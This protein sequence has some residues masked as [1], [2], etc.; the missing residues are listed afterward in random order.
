MADP[1]PLQWLIDQAIG[2]RSAPLLLA[3]AAG[4]F[5]A[6]APRQGLNAVSTLSNFRAANGFSLRLRRDAIRHAGRQGAG[7]HSRVSPGHNQFP[8][9]RD[10][11]LLTDSLHRGM[12]QAIALFT[13]VA[14]AALAVYH[15]ESRLLLAA[16]PLNLSP[17]A[18][19]RRFGP[20]LNDAA[21][22][23]Q[24]AAAAASATL[25][26]HLNAITQ[27]QLPPGL[28]WRERFVFSGS[29]AYIRA[30]AHKQKTEL[31]FGAGAGLVTAGGLSSPILIAGPRLVP[32]DMTA[33]AFLG[34]YLC[35]GQLCTPA[36]RWSDPVN[37]LTQTR[38][39]LARV[40]AFLTEPVNPSEC[41]HPQGSTAPA[42]VDLTNVAFAFPGAFPGGAAILEI[43]R[44]TVNP[45]EIL[46][47]IG[48][49]GSGKTILA[50]LPLR[51]FDPQ[52]GAIRYNGVRLAEMELRVLRGVIAF[53]P[54]SPLFF[55]GTIRD[56]LRA[57]W[58]QFQR[59]LGSAA[60]GR[61]RSWGC[62]DGI[63]SGRAHG[64]GRRAAF[65]RGT[66]AS[67]ACPRL[68]AERRHSDSG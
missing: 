32:G 21:A 54:Q 26:D 29:V 35:L 9:E 2:G 49:S 64:T 58:C 25:Q 68:V 7:Y 44:L 28:R 12:V 33:G 67:G 53:C 15:F 65:R 3:G 59:N 23:S 20:A 17:L 63:R 19:K 61:A 56:N 50:R 41:S 30:A 66:A 42:A 1:F 10:V 14:F 40:Q 24:T 22:A 13:S 45:G 43:N 4:L 18:L 37:R 11:E 38:T 48:P 51:Q 47:I 36:L 57:A 16:V 52:R 46:A 39:I 55:S 5:A 31:I 62:R 27:I 6:S 34:T 60:A 8:I